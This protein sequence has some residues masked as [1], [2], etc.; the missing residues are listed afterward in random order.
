MVVF[1]LLEAVDFESG[2]TVACTEVAIVIDERCEAGS[3]KPGC[4][5]VQVLLFQTC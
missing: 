1:N 4:E 5:V 2:M 3:L